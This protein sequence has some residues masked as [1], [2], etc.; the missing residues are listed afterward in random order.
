[1]RPSAA[2]DYQT[3]D[4]GLPI[5]MVENIVIKFLCVTNAYADRLT[6]TAV[7]SSNTQSAV[8]CFYR[9]LPITNKQ[10]IFY[11]YVHWTQQCLILGEE[12]K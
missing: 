8:N 2:I 3:Y 1:M 5:K 4:G 6:A 7:D 12:A 11:T 10:H 9:Y